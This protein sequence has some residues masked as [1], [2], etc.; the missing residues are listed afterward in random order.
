MNKITDSYQYSY[1]LCL[2]LGMVGVVIGLLVGIIDT[3]FGRVLLYAGEVRSAALPYL[4]PFLGL[5]GL[6][7]VFL[8]QFFSKEAQ[9]GMALIFEVAHGE[10]QTIPLYLIPL[11]VISTWLT[12][13]FGGSA[14]REGVAVQL[15]ATISHRFTPY[16]TFPNSTQI[17]VVTGMAAGFAGLFQTP[18]AALFFALEVLTIGQL[19]LYA[20]IPCLFA[21]YTASSFSHLLGLE[22]FS[23]FLSF[24]QIITVDVFLKCVLLGILFGM[25]GNLFV[26]FQNLLKK[27]LA[28][29]VK[30]P[31]WRIFMMG[32][33]LSLA[34]GF[35]HFGRYSGL[36]TNLI[37]ASFS[38]QQ[39]Y[40][41]DF[42]LK[43][44]FTTLTLAAGFQGGEVTPLFAI[45][46]S[47]GVILAPIVGLPVELVAATG[48]ISVF[49]SATNTLLAPI[50]IGGEVFGFQNLPFFTI[51]IIISYIL[52]RSQSIY[53]LQRSLSI[54]GE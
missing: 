39:I 41:Y 28:H 44:L 15:G 31:Y 27:R 37:E 14:G 11:V 36:G 54:G 53:G 20:L 17:L 21:V 4:L 32:I 5:A 3:I 45:G 23:Y 2:Y 29:Y 43:L 6:V 24:T 26:Y 48:Y 9:K 35:S 47:L 12:H 42:L 13:L 52:N 1:R 34:L 38:T 49:A 16:F 19:Q 50:L 40:S 10:R 7:I 25:T 51:T 46:A 22:K 30:N 18:L 33:L 8:Y